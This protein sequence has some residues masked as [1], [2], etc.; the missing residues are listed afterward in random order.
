MTAQ[1]D[2]ATAVA[3]DELAAC[4]RVNTN[5]GDDT[6]AGRA[7]KI[8]A[9][10]TVAKAVRDASVVAQAL[11]SAAEAEP[12]ELVPRA[13]WRPIS[14]TAASPPWLPPPLTP[15]LPLL[16]RPGRRHQT[17]RRI[18]RT[19]RPLLLPRHAAK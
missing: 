15:V 3:R 18:H 16:R 11:R 9:L 5:G 8:A 17:R 10:D 19:P 14:A 2:E 4:F 6:H 13:T 12:T 1:F 7:Q